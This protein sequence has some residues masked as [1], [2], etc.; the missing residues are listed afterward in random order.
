MWKIA[1]KNRKSNVNRIIV[2]QRRLR[3]CINN[4]SIDFPIAHQVST[5]KVVAMS[6][7]AISGLW[8]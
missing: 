7:S 3:L 1:Y 6:V 4:V 5:S 2:S 8:P